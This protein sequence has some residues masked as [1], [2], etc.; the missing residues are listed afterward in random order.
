MEQHEHHSMSI[1][2]VAAITGTSSWLWYRVVSHRHV[3]W[4]LSANTTKGTCF[5][6]IFSWQK[7]WFPATFPLNYHKLSIQ[8]PSKVVLQQDL[9]DQYEWFSIGSQWWPGGLAA[10]LFSWSVGCQLVNKLFGAGNFI[11]SSIIWPSKYLWTWLK[12]GKTSKKWAPYNILFRCLEVIDIIKG[13]RESLFFLLWRFV[14][15]VSCLNAQRGPRQELVI[16]RNGP[17]AHPVVW[18]PGA[19]D[20]ISPFCD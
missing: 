19:G 16:E 13:P 2:F 20:R 3:D 1:Q 4:S 5:F 11:I 12:Y 15:Q 9:P 6:L 17:M 7:N 18:L 8:S 14:V 10:Q